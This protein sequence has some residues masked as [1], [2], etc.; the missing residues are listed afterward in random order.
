MVPDTVF[1]FLV[2]F[3]AY[4]TALAYSSVHLGAFAIPAVAGTLRKI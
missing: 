3:H 1:D 4:S 2:A